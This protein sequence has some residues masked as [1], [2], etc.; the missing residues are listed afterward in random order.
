MSD[1]IQ[2]HYDEDFVEKFLSRVKREVGYEIIEAYTGDGYGGGKV[3]L[4]GYYDLEELKSI[5]VAWE[6]I[7][8]EGRENE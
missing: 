1:T 5:V 7:K 4:S 6:E 3:L 8:K 2:K